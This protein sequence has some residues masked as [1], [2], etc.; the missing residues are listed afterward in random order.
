MNRVQIRW[1]YTVG[2]FVAAARLWSADALEQVDQSAR[3]WVQLRLES[4]RL[5]TAWRSERQLVESTLA[6]LQERATISEEKRDLAKARTAQERNDLESLRAKTQAAA[7]DLRAADARLRAL[8][9]RLQALR[10]HLPPRLAEALEM[11]Y[12]SLA[13]TDR[14]FAERM[15]LAINILNRCAQF[16]R[17]ITAAED[18]LK[19]DAAP[20]AKSYD[21]VYW[22]LGCGYA[23]DRTTKQA[24]LGS[25]GADGWRWELRPDAFAA[26]SEAYAIARD[27][28]DP[29][30]VILPAPALKNVAATPGAS[31]P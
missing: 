18:V 8:T 14:P 1:L 21:V 10:P 20:N 23:I 16:N 5:E 27:K 15:Q 29:A 12:R 25:P 26:A 9:E 30:F 3:D 13:Q 22:G 6:A 31:A 7:E 11:S 4:T 2:W 24:W 28:G 19:L 17:V